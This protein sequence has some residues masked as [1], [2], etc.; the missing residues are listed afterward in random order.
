MLVH[1]PGGKPEACLW[2][3]DDLCCSACSAQAVPN[4]NSLGLLS[5]LSCP[6]W[7]ASL[8]IY[9]DQL[10]L[11]CHRTIVPAAA[12]ELLSDT[13]TTALHPALRRRVRQD[14]PPAQSPLHLRHG[15]QGKLVTKAQRA[16]LSIGLL[17]IDSVCSPST[18]QP[19]GLCLSRCLTRSANIIADISCLVLLNFGGA[20]WAQL[21]IQQ[22]AP[23]PPIAAYCVALYIRTPA[24]S[25][26]Y[27]HGNGTVCLACHKCVCCL[28]TCTIGTM[29]LLPDAGKQHYRS[30]MRLLTFV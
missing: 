6:V 22:Q 17:V 20:I 15:A 16:L 12:A 27:L 23:Q 8:D 26:R 2:M 19:T 25:A 29:P 24:Q 7:A 13:I 14:I 28:S 30:C 10:C 18:Q 5:M 3:V 21:S 1:F 4:Q 9:A 11:H